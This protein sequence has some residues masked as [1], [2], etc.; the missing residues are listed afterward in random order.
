ELLAVLRDLRRPY[1]ARRDP[2]DSHAGVSTHE[3]RLSAR[4]SAHSGSPTASMSQFLALNPQEAGLSV[5]GWPGRFVRRLDRGFDRAFGEHDNPLR[6][7]GGLAFYLFWLVT[8]SGAYL[9]IFY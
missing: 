9:Y 5:G 3:S 4:G 1:D 8:V 7:L 6:Q 2:L